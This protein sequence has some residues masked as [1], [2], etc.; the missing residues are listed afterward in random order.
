MTRW[1]MSGFFIGGSG[2]EMSSKAMV[3][4]IPACSSSGSGSVSIGFSSAFW[5]A[6]STSRTGRQRLRRV[7]H[8]GA[9]RE[10]LQ[11][12]ALTVVHEQRRRPVVHLEHETLAETCQNLS[13]RTFGALMRPSHRMRP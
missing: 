6:P 12:E 9:E 8:P 2:S 10:R 13:R 1:R 5:I 11:P 7:D 4:R 3:S